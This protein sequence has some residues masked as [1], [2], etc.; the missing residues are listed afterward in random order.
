MAAT[1]S[2]PFSLRR[3]QENQ[4]RLANCGPFRDATLSIPEDGPSSY[5]KRFSR[6]GRVNHLCVFATHR[7]VVLVCFWWRESFSSLSS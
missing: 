4:K 2:L 3:R 5:F 7:L 1:N 6:D